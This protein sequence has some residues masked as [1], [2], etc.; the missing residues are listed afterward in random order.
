MSALRLRF[1]AQRTSTLFRPTTNTFSRRCTIA[2]RSHISKAFTTSRQLCDTPDHNSRV[3]RQTQSH[4]EQ[5][6]AVQQGLPIPDAE[7]QIPTPT[8]LPSHAPSSSSSSSSSASTTVTSNASSQNSS[9]AGPLSAIV[10]AYDRNQSSHP[11]RTQFWTS[12]LIYL[13]GDLSAQ[14]L[15]GGEDEEGQ[16]KAYDPWRTMRHLT[17]GAVSSIPSF[18]W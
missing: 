12:I 6:E 2:S 10:R 13:C 4:V 16:M 17:V 3:S 18:K 9:R 1:V 14:L 15:F 8:P 7:S 11:Y 5:V